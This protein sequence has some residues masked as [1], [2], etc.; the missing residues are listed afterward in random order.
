M[1]EISEYKT[2][3]VSSVPGSWC[4]VE[5]S[6]QPYLGITPTLLNLIPTLPP[7]LFGISPRAYGKPSKKAFQEIYVMAKR[8]FWS[9]S[10]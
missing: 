7:S 3:K 10:M 2:N 4:V 8:E 9:E 5:P 1:I 6:T